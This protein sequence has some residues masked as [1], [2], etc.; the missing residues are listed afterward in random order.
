MCLGH[1]VDELHNEHS[2]AHACTAKQANLATTLVGRQQVHHLK[3]RAW[4]WEAMWQLSTS[5]ELSSECG[6]MHQCCERT[7]MPVTK[8]SCS[9]LCS[10]NSG[11]SRW[12]DHCSVASASTVAGSAMQAQKQP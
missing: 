8:I 4:F 1:V 9:V 2:L 10:V 11:A 12:M 3:Q 7:L 6:C 5:Y